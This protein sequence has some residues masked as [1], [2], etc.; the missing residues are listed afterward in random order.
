MGNKN[1]LI[2]VLCLVIVIIIACCN[3]NE[4][5]KE[6][7]KKEMI[8]QSQSKPENQED[9][10]NDNE[11]IINYSAFIIKSI[12]D[13][14]GLHL[15]DTETEVKNILGK[16][17]SEE[18]CEEGGYIG[19]P[20]FIREYKSGVRIILG[21]NSRKVLEIV[22]F[23]KSIPTEQGIE[24]RD[25]SEKALKLYRDKYK[26]FKGM[27]SDGRIPGWFMVEKNILLIF[28][29]DLTD[30]NRT[31]E[32]MNSSSEVEEIVLAYSWLFE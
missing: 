26:E 8:E 17:Y 5:N 13:L 6:M 22:V 7:P 1:I 32:K 19:E 20:F 21:K 24:V 15:G 14:A 27:Y 12:I 11:E 10:N 25:S 29:F 23:K 16:N 3:N 4:P 9:K 18:F 30:S 28:D 2:P 31:N